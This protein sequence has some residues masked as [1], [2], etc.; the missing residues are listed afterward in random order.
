MM[1]DGNGNDGRR[2]T[3]EFPVVASVNAGIGRRTVLAGLFALA[4]LPSAASAASVQYAQLSYHWFT[5]PRPGLFS[6]LR[7]GLRNGSIAPSDRR[8]RGAGTCIFAGAGQAWIQAGSSGYTAEFGAQMV[9]LDNFPI[10]LGTEL[11]CAAESETGQYIGPRIFSFHYSSPRVKQLGTWTAGGTFSVNLAGGEKFEGVAAECMLHIPAG[12]GGARPTR[13]DGRFRA[14][15]IN[16]NSTG[17][18]ISDERILVISDG[19]MGCEV[20]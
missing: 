19:S 16:S 7:T 11:A 2:V 8:I 5:P 18:A 17:F 12:V 15:L 3:S 4:T 6:T 13:G 14:A 10:K 9:P 20:R 1:W